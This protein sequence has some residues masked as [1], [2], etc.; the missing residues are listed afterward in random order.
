MLLATERLTKAYPGSRGRLAVS[1]ADVTLNRGET[2]GL[3]GDSGSGKSTLGLMIAGLLKP[4]AGRILYDG[5][6]VSM[7]FRG[8]VRRN[9]QI[10]F[11]HAE[12]AFNPALILLRSM[13]EPYKL[14][15]P[16]YSYERLVADLEP[17]GLRE[18]HLYRHP[19]QLSGGELQRAALARILTIRP[20]VVVLDEPTS[21]LDLITQ[22]QIMDM[23]RGYQ[24]RH[25]TSYVL[26]SH[27][28]A[29]CELMCDRIYRV[30]DGV[31]TEE[32]R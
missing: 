12:T 3:Y 8:E 13:V 24:E 6:E 18:E 20:D 14:H 16:P 5:R 15:A 28:R 30:D 29:L 17:Y 32:A 4:S 31:F 26:I 19:D 23:L 10:L 9:I 7:P 27:S 11:Q 25:G 22:A 2:V 1:E 21:M